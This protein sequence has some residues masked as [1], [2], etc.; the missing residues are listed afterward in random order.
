MSPAQLIVVLITIAVIFGGVMTIVGYGSYLE[1]KGSAFVQDR[2]GPNRVGFD[3]NQPFLFF[4]KGL[5]GLGQ[6]LADGVKFLLKE[7]LA[8]PFVDKVFFYLAPVIAFSTALIAFAVVPVGSTSVVPPLV[9]Y[10]ADLNSGKENPDYGH[11]VYPR[12]EKE[13][14]QILRADPLRSEKVATA[15]AK[16]PSFDSPFKLGK[17]EIRF[18]IAPHV[19]LGVL[20]VF[21]VSS[22]AV[23]GVVLGGWSSNSKYALLGSLRSSAQ[24]IS[25]EIPMG[26][27]I[28][29]V[30]YMA[31][32]LNLQA[33]VEYQA[34]HGWFVV[35]QPLGFLLFFTAIFAECNRLPFDLPECEQEL[36][37]GYHTEYSSMKFICFMIAEYAHMVTT[38]FLLVALFL[39]G[40]HLPFLVTQDWPEAP[41][42]WLV[43]LIVFGGKMMAI[44]CFFILI[45]WT[46]LRFRFDQLMSLAWKGMMILGILNTLG[47]VVILYF[48]P[49]GPYHLWLL[50][51]WSLFSIVFVAALS[52]FRPKP[53]SRFH[54][55]IR[56]VDS[57]PQSLTSG[58]LASSAK[59][60]VSSH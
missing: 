38:S 51:A 46:L 43:R 5:V 40:W 8:P 55:G 30:L 34:V 58:A 33:I 28:L 54:T 35:I 14:A 44:I 16:N 48:K 3:F 50:P 42:M 29:I 26:M 56:S 19:D 45:R 22:L 37:G 36:V 2:V 53:P 9:D 27:S 15:A 20:F 21:A 10:R 17:A 1:R 59:S 47:S 6:P 52:F 57:R 24:L 11:R 18:G 41:V 25:Y 12:T 13:L 23:Y 7:E 31:G 60:A 39:G 49:L 32:S 4:L